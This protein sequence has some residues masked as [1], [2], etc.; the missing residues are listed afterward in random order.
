MW[1]GVPLLEA[2]IA[3]LKTKRP[4]AIN[5]YQRALELGN[6]RPGVVQHLIGLLS[7]DN[8]EAEIDKVLANLRDQENAPAELKIANA[9]SAM[10]KG[11]FKRGVA[12]AEELFKESNRHIDHLT[13]GRFY[14]MAGQV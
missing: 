13:L 12:L 9:I 10:R 6:S 11:D 5:H 3:E 4:E 7:Q 14:A 1:W 2:Q 8:R